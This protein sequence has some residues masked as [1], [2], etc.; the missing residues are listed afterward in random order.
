M[1]VVPQQ[2]RNAVRQIVNWGTAGSR[3]PDATIM[4][5]LDPR[6]VYSIYDI[7]YST[8]RWNS[9]VTN[10]EYLRYFNPQDGLVRE[11]NPFGPR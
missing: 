5:R 8:M 3:R 1:Q 4:N 7:T 6:E 10:R 2:S 11:L 9:V